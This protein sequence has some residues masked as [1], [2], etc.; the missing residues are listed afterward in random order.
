M[1]STVS[2]TKR[3]LAICCRI[4]RSM[5]LSGG[6]VLLSCAGSG[7]SAGL[8]LRVGSSVGSAVKVQISSQQAICCLRVA[9]QLAVSD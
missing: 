7:T 5:L 8:V 2:W 4:S 6:S 1:K 3:G 9:A